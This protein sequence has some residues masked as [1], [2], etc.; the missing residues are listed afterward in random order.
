MQSYQNGPN[1]P[2][3]GYVKG[4][5]GKSENDVKCD[6]VTNATMVQSGTCFKGTL[7]S[8]EAGCSEI[9]FCIPFSTSITIYKL[10]LDSIQVYRNSTNQ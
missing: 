3:P 4:M 5:V 8:H 2:V 1:I 9:H 6:H 7:L 10:N